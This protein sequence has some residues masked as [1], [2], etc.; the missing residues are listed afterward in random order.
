MQN[1]GHLLFLAHVFVF[2]LTIKVLSQCNL[3]AYL[4]PYHASHNV[5]QF[6]LNVLVHIFSLARPTSQLL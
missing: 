2:F 1:N 6:I 3:V 5:N 4:P